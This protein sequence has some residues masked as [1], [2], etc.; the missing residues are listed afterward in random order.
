VYRRTVPKDFQDLVSDD[1]TYVKLA[2]RNLTTVPE[3]IKT[4]TDLTDLDLAGNQLAAVPD[5]FGDLAALTIL[6]LSGN[7]LTAVPDTL[8]NLTALT[9]L[10]L[11]GNQLAAVPDTFGD[12][13]ALTILDLSGNQLTAVPDTLGNLTALTRLDLDRNQLVTLPMALADLLIGR[14]ELSLASNPLA[15]PLPQLAERGAES[16]A[17]YLRSLRDAKRQYE[18]KLL[19]VGEGNVGK[20]SL[21]TAL[22]AGAFVEGRETTHGIEI[23]PVTMPH[24]DLDEQL[25]L[26]SWDFG[27]Q[28]I[29]RVTHQFFFGQR[30]CT[31]WCGMPGKV[32]SKTR[33]RAG[34]AGSGSGSARMR[35]S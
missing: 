18:A 34:C 9:G 2:K 32:T 27:G 4:L 15:D 1:G 31:W 35:A 26:R 11:A 13:A 17:A 10:N 5:T 19:L 16:L 25:T 7:Q 20:T 33:S 21:V 23:W 8:G 29:Y 28:E 22:R 3:W 6:D 30:R 12:L 24:P 14:L